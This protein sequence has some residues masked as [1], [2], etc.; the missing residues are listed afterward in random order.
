MG[1]IG[2]AG[3]IE[4]G[5]LSHEPD[6]RRD[7]AGHLSVGQCH[8][9]RVGELSDLR[10]QRPRELIQVNAPAVG[11]KLVPSVAVVRGVCT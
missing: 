9:A 6:L 2:V 3:K 8:V 1:V 4:M 10:R 11:A 5:E 7:G